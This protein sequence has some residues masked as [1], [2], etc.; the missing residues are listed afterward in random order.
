MIQ[1]GL[2]LSF[3]SAMSKKKKPHQHL[4][5]TAEKVIDNVHERESD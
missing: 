1:E 3:R 5:F 4:E 2:D